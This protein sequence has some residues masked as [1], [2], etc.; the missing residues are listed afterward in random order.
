MQKLQEDLS[1]R[2]AEIEAKEHQRKILAKEAREK[3]EQA[4]IVAEKEQGERIQAVKELAEA[5]A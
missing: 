2:Q 4:R 3:L 5:M 1:R